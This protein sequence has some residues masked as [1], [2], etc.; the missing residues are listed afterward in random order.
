MGAAEVRRAGR[1]RDHRKF[2]VAATKSMIYAPDP[3]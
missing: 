3:I 1:V 2:D